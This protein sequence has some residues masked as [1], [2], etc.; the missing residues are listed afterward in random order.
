M[1]IIMSIFIFS[2]LY[3]NSTLISSSYEWTVVVLLLVDYLLSRILGSN[4]SFILFFAL[5]L[6]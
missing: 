6:G 1:M 3:M 4:I 5:R 2:Y